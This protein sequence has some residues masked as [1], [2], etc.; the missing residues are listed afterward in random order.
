MTDRLSLPPKSFRASFL[1]PKSFFRQAPPPAI[2]TNATTSDNLPMHYIPFISSSKSTSNF[3][4][5]SSTP[6]PLGS[7][8]LSTPA[9]LLGTPDFREPK[10]PTSRFRR[11]SLDRLLDSGQLGGIRPRQLGALEKFRVWTVNQGAAHVVVG[12]F[13]V[14]HA[15]LFSLA[16]LHYHKKDYYNNNR[17]LFGLTFQLARASAEVLSFDVALILLPMCRTILSY[18]R[19]SPLNGIIPFDKNVTFHKLVG[20][21]LVLFSIVHVAAHWNNL[22]KYAR[23]YD[24]GFKEWLQLNFLTGPGWSGYLMILIL[25]IMLLTAI[26]RSRNANY[27]RFWYTHHLFT[28]FFVL[29]SI[30]GCFCILKK[31]TGECA[32]TGSFYKYWVFGAVLYLAERIAREVRGRHK[33][34]ISKVIQHPANVVEIQMFKEKTKLKPG[35]YIFLNVPAVSAWQYHPF[36]ITSAPEEDHLSIHVRTVG[37]FTKELG[38]ILGANEEAEK[39]TLPSGPH[40]S[41]KQD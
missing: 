28:L 15:L 33:T 34:F 27:E 38:E 40:L 14:V 10:I 31:D 25:L 41:V 37:N 8:A 5:A 39:K 19:E 13:A 23:F 32:S 1:R 35:Q 36:T 9:T 18:L 12:I 22:L 7:S 21:S 17:Q 16:F 2:R 4:S 24:G 6:T 30:H 3:S 20:Y 26:D 29:F 11:T